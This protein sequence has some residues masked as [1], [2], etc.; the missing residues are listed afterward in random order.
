MDTSPIPGAAD[1]RWRSVLLGEPPYQFR[2]A[3]AGMLFA[4][5]R[6]QLAADPSHANFL[7]SV[8]QARAF[9]VKYQLAMRDEIA[10]LFY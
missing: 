1:Y 7:A 5:L 8:A 3:T 9:L 10:E 4:R 6:R 2:S